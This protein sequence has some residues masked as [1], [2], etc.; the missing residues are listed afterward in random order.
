[1]IFESDVVEIKMDMTNKLNETLIDAIARKPLRDIEKIIRE[2]ACVNYR[3]E[4]GYTP[5]HYAC[6]FG[7]TNIARILISKGANIEA[8]CDAGIT[9]LYS[10]V[11]EGSLDCF[12]FMVR[13][14]ANIHKTG[15]NGETVLHGAVFI[16]PFFYHEKLEI[17]KAILDYGVD[18][19]KKLVDGQTALD[20]A[21]NQTYDVFHIIE[22]NKKIIKLLE[23]KMNQ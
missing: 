7:R 10:S 16:R 3:G 8:E 1:L 13:Q 22:L 15:I 2:G 18:P 12:D 21:K 20:I 6:C 17:I 4:F 23:D 14:N 19:H 5:L 11:Q 9:P